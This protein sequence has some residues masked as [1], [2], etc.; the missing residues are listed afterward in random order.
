[1][2][3]AI[4]ISIGGSLIFGIDVNIEFFGELKKILIKNI[5][6]YN[7]SIVCGGGNTARNYAT[8]AK[9]IGL[10]EEK[11]DLLGIDATRM[12][13]K[14]I[15]F[16]LDNFTTGKIYTNIEKLADDFGEK[17][18]IC[19]GMKPGQRTDK[20]AALIAKKLNIKTLINLTNVDG[21]FNKD[22]KKNLDAKFIPE[23]NYEQFCNLSRMKEHKPSYHFV[24]DYDAAEICY[25]EKIRVII[26]NGEKLHNLDNYLA[27][28]NFKGSII[29]F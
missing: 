15:L 21:V 11:Q 29:N 3:E 17:I 20:V 28:K 6:N 5:G 25:E 18:T 9:K 27:K 4:V 12:N 14:L 24:F 13:A 8:I 7:F 2:K 1:M 23:L 26:L 10:S 16:I 19:G 22:P